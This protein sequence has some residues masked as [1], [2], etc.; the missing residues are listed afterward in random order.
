MSLILNQ[1]RTYLKRLSRYIPA[2]KDSEAVDAI[3][4]VVAENSSSDVCL[5]PVFAR[6]VLL[7]LLKNYHADFCS[8]AELILAVA[9]PFGVGKSVMVTETCRR[10]GVKVFRLSV[11]ELSSEWEG[12][13]AKTV[14]QRYY[15]ASK[16]QIDQDIPCCLVID[17][18]DLA[19]GSFSEF[20]SGTKNTQHL[21]NVVMEIADNPTF[22]CGHE[23]TRVPIIATANDLSKVY[24]AVTRPGRMKA[25]AYQPG[26]DEI[27]EIG[28]HIIGDL[29]ADHQFSRLRQ[30]CRG[31]VT[32]HFSQLKSIFEERMLEHHCSSVNARDCIYD[33]FRSESSAKARCAGKI[34]YDDLMD[35]VEEIEKCRNAAATS[36]VD[37]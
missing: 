6:T 31:W 17:D 22:V 23:T 27:F 1:D 26:E 30:Y 10:L 37:C 21:I 25:W 36:Y 29:L 16:S 28:R 18:V 12:Q 35:A 9:G 19:I 24:G 14:A 34:T 13:P 11:T 4:S 5:D 8:S 2:Q 7:H 32:A 20:G 3:V 15:Q 33:A